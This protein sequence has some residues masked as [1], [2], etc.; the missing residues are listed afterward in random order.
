MN[1]ATEAWFRE[2]AHTARILWI[3]EETPK[4]VLGMASGSVVPGKEYT[5]LTERGK[6]MVLSTK[7]HAYAFVEIM[8]FTAYGI[9]PKQGASLPMNNG[10]VDLG[11]IPDDVN[12]FVYAIERPCTQGEFTFERWFDP[13]GTL[14]NAND[15]TLQFG[16]R[17]TGRQ[18]SPTVFEMDQSLFLGT[19]QQA[20]GMADAD[21]AGHIRGFSLDADKSGLI[22]TPLDVMR[23]TAR[24]RAEKDHGKK[25]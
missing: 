22:L 3:G 12:G 16:K 15:H 4:H 18:N 23:S 1:K 5:I 19:I 7:H 8:P 21:L 13:D 10:I 25:T 11:V 14:W 24:E 20:R 9:R 2:D 17:I 6:S